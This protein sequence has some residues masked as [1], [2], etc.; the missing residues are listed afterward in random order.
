MRRAAFVLS[1][2]IHWLN[3]TAAEDI[4][5]LCMNDALSDCGGGRVDLTLQAAFLH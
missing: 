3:E 4:R 5:K 2:E 1:S